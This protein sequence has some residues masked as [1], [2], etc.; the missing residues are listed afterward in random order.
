MFVFFFAC[1]YIFI[2]NSTLNLFTW[3][4]MQ[5]ITEKKKVFYF[6]S[7]LSSIVFSGIGSNFVMRWHWCNNKVIIEMLFFCMRMMTVGR[8]WTACRWR[9]RNDNAYYFYLKK[10]KKI[11]ELWTSIFPMMNAKKVGGE[12][13]E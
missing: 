5:T 6:P 4:V 12:K 10:K 3:K 9:K 8:W 13:R 11:R 1:K 2:V 7:S